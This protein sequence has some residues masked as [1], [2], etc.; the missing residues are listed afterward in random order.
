MTEIIQKIFDVIEIEYT[1]EN[2]RLTPGG[3]IQEDQ[4]I[5]KIISGII[6]LCYI[7]DV[8]YDEK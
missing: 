8:M 6:T 7:F 2:S 1:Q 4:P 5:L 3:G